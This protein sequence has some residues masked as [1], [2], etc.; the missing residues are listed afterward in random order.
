MLL[1]FNPKFFSL[2]P[3]TGGVRGHFFI[4]WTLKSQCEGL[5]TEYLEAY[6]R[7]GRTFQGQLQQNFVV[8]RD[9]V[10]T[11]AAAKECPSYSTPKKRQ[12]KEE[13]R[14]HPGKRGL[15]VGEAKGRL[16]GNTLGIQDYITTKIKK[17][18]L[19]KKWNL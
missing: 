10:S 3:L 19:L 4:T 9:R 5:G 6:R 13:S 18:N 7:A 2:E 17:F 1:A 12:K 15:K 8:L 14:P 11:P 16:R